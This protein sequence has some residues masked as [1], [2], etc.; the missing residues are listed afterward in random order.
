MIIQWQPPLL[1]LL[2]VEIIRSLALLNHG[3]AILD[4]TYQLAE[5]ASDAFIFF[6][7]IR[8][9]RMTGGKT[10]RLMRSVFAGDITQPAM[11]AFFRIDTSH[12]MIIQV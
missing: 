6:N 2:P 4:R 7:S 12:D 1:K 11:D 8:V 3:D 10:D 9:I 5:I